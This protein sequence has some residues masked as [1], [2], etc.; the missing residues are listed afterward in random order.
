MAMIICDALS[1]PHTEPTTCGH[2][3]VVKPSR[4][5]GHVEGFSFLTAYFPRRTGVGRV[6]THRP[7]AFVAVSHLVINAR[8]GVGNIDSTAGFPLAFPLVRGCE[9]ELHLQ[10]G[11][12]S[13]LGP[14]DVDVNTRHSRP[15]NQNQGSPQ[16]QAV[17]VQ[18]VEFELEDSLCT[19]SSPASEETHLGD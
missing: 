16:I 19:Q 12:C 17:I 7:V 2:L 10:M 18:L 3:H 8:P 14:H 1:A 15:K 4:N 9:L 6:R 11:E 5:R 13:H